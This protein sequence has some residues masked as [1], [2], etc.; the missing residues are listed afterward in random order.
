MQNAHEVD[1]QQAPASSLSRAEVRA[2]AIA[3]PPASGEQ[4]VEVV[5]A[6]VSTVTRAE[7]RADLRAA[8]ASGYQV[9][10]GE[11]N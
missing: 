2:Q 5:A 8:L 6:P 11:R 10:A 7:V 1:P 9:L 3:Q 4:S